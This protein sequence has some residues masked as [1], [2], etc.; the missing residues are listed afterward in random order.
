[1][2]EFDEPACNKMSCSDSV[3]GLRDNNLK[4]VEDR[5][6][7]KYRA[8]SSISNLRSAGSEGVTFAVELGRR[9]KY[10]ERKMGFP[11]LSSWV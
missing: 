2:E 11:L 1:M 10:L 8:A 7:S 6:T 5:K 3:S 4:E 9:G